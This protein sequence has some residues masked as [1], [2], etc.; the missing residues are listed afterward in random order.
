MKLN[1][2]LRLNGFPS[3]V[4]SS[5]IFFNPTTLETKIQIAMAAI[6]I[7]TE[8][9]KKSKKSKN[10]MPMIV[11]LDNGPYPKHESVPKPIII[12]PKMIV[13]FFLDQCSSSWNVDTALSVNA[14]ELVIAANNTNKKKIMPMPV[15]NPILANTLGIVMNIKDGP[16]FNVSISPPEKEN[17]AGIIINPAMIAM[18]V[19]KIS[20]FSVEPSIETSFFI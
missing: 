5:S 12:I 20:T 9:V 14:I 11:T 18:A 15:P 10:C 4:I 3:C 8:F 19:S 2:F 13:D 17:T 6:G 1:I 7:M 16:A